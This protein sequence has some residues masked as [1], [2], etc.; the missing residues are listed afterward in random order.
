MSE[1]VKIIYPR[2]INVNLIDKTYS[3]NLFETLLKQNL[4]SGDYTTDSS[5]NLDDNE[6]HSGF[7]IK[8][9]YEEEI[10][11][12]YVSA[13]IYTQA[14]VQNTDIEFCIP[15]FPRAGIL[16]SK[17]IN[18]TSIPEDTE[19]VE[20][21]PSVSS[22]DEDFI[23]N[24]VGMNIF[25][26]NDNVEPSNIETE[27]SKTSMTIPE[28]TEE[29]EIEPS[30][31]NTD[32]DF[33]LK[34]NAT[35]SPL[36]IKHSTITHLEFASDIDGNEFLAEQIKI[37]KEIAALI[38]EC[39][40][41]SQRIITLELSPKNLGY[42]NIELITNA[43]GHLEKISFTVSNDISY[44]SLNSSLSLLDHEINKLYPLHTL[45]E[46]IELELHM[47]SFNQDSKDSH[48]KD[49]KLQDIYIKTPTQ[50]KND[51]V[52]QQDIVKSKNLVDLKI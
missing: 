7:N 21:E 4:L 40:N 33:I 14:E 24:M 32:E 19:E 10:D 1:Q 36:H 43:Q 35:I 30:V 38:R 52:A 45:S 11:N 46:D 16:E 3:S 13:G 12:I 6:K 8:D 22:T 42:M 15:V 37:T 47:G 51:N 29:V 41:N 20:I 50:G 9:I 28:D 25:Q 48:K 34:P 39:Q 27:E 2:K 44:N 23:L 31:S 49:T 5:T 17:F 26:Q 18:L